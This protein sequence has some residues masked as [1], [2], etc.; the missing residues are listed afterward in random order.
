V[1]TLIKEGEFNGWT[2]WSTWN[3]ALWIENDRGLYTLA[4]QFR[5]LGYKAFVNSLS[6]FGLDISVQTPDGVK[7]NDP[8]LDIEALDELMGEL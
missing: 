4:R 3:V 2:N 6:E 1:L 7:W 8:T 5:R